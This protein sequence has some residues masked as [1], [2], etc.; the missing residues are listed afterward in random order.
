MRIALLFPNNTYTS[1]YL[2]YYTQL[3][4]KE[5]LEYDLI[6]WD[7][8]GIKEEGCLAFSQKENRKSIYTRA[9]GFFKYRNFII[10]KI[11]EN[12]YD[13]IIV[14]SC[15][16]GILLSRYIT[17]KYKNNF[18]LDIRDYSKV[19]PFF[20]NRFR[21]LVLN[22]NTV[23][24]SSNGFKEWLPKNRDYLLS[25]NIDIKLIENR[26]KNVSNNKTFFNDQILNID[27]IG[28]IKDYNSDKEVIN[29]LKND[30]RFH[31]TFIG[32]GPTLEALKQ[33]INEN[34]VS[35][36]HFYGPY[37]KEEEKQLLAKTD[38]INILISRNKFN[39]GVTSNRL[40]LS[41]LLNIPCIVNA[42][43]IEQRKIIEKYKFGIIVDKYEELPNKLIEYKETFNNEVF[44]DNCLAF[45]N[46]VKKDYKIFENRL[47]NFI[48]E[49]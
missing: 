19:L 11:N 45:L 18:L 23:C 31:M 35:N 26:L 16:L 38:F 42:Q 33:Y 20:N 12:E 25:H 49:K 32:F 7:R 37:K 9:S 43:T 4:E 6:I 5:N 22:A 36:V 21:K 41:A 44:I 8:A 3:L 27:T 48:T 40:Y 1:P 39:N 46:N 34:K 17:K 13:K 47:I 14:F 15:Q 24:I 2:K 30:K 10:Q 29:Q 28:Q